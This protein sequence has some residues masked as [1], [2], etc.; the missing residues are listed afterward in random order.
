MFYKWI[1]ESESDGKNDF[2]NNSVMTVRQW[3]LVLMV[4]MI[5][6]INIV[7]ILRWAFADKEF[8][9]SNKVNWARAS[10]IVFTALFAVLT[11]F[12]IVGW[13]VTKH[14]L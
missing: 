7:M 12:I 14:Y 9:P 11:G 1:N 3:M 5:P 10:A 2:Y 6:V 13:V 4:T 8:T